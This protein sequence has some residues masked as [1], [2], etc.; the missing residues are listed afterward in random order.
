MQA[1]S[2]GINPAGWAACRLL[3]GVWPGCLLGRLNGLK[4]IQ[5]PVPEL[6]GPRWV[7]LKTLM[8]GICGTD[9]GLIAQ[10]QRPDSILQ[11]YSSLPAILGHETLAV[12]DEVGP[13]V[14]SSWLGRRVCVD[15]TL[16]CAVRGIHPP[17]DR[18]AAGQ[19]GAC[20]NFD[21]DL[22]G[23]YRLPAG[24]SIGYNARLGGAYA[25][26]FLAHDSQLVAVPDELLDEQAVLTDPVGCGLHA[27]LRA[28]LANTGRVL[29]Y[30]AGVLG[31]SVVASLR[32]VGYAGRIDAL[33]RAGYVEPVALAMGADELVRLPS[34]TPSRF[35]AIAART[36]G[37]VHRVRFGN[38]MLSGGYDII[39]D[40]VGSRQSVNE[41]LKWAR[42]RGQVAIIGTGYGG[43]IDLTPLWFTELTM[44][45]AYGR[46]VE[47][48]GGR[49]IRTY[50]LVH[51]LMV[52]G[53]LKVGRMLTHTFRLGEYREAFE[54][55]LHKGRHEA[56]K[57]AFDMRND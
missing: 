36:G 39:F 48:F 12:V 34:D 17:C 42:S 20:E 32:A 51:E 14:D 18:C 40:C 43:Q 24:T 57:V 16:C 6:P 31:L 2:Y 47:T 22:P 27:V 50:Q 11:A 1:I 35:E 3:R 8:A 44:L 38:Y 37:R 25:D 56:I 53:K 29:V 4:M 13:E 9:L 10:R 41:S 49:E 19:Y 7:R 15:P 52:S 55:G 21:G 5:A 23:D 33:D 45:G 26:Y 30:G 28:K 46:Q 54:V